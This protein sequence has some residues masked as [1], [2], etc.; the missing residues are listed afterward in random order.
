[1]I[2]IADNQSFHQLCEELDGQPFIT[3]DTEF[4]RERTYFPILALVQVSWRGQDPLLIDPLAVDDWAPF[5]RVL[6]N[7]EV[8]KVFHAG[9]QDV[10]IF[11]HQMK[12]LPQNLFDTQVAASM[13]GFGDQIGYG[14]LTAKLLGVQLAKGSSYTNW[15]Q[16]PLTKAQL[17]YAREDVAYLPDLYERLVAESELHGRLQ[18][19]QEE[20]N[21]QFHEAL[22]RPDPEEL[23]QKVKKGRNLRPR[24]LAVLR[25]LAKWRDESARRVNKPVRFL[26]PDEAMVE[27]SKIDRL[28]E[29]HLRARRNLQAG[30]ID[31]FGPVLIQLHSRARELPRDQWP[32]PRQERE[33]QPSEK[34]E[35]LAD[36]AWLL[37]KEIARSASIAP[38][39][40]VS[41]KN[42]AGFI[43]AY[44]RKKDLSRFSFYTGWRKEMVGEPLT[45]LIEGKL[46]V[47]VKRQKIIWE[48]APES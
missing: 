39:N 45:R 46:L 24:D 4:I 29:E 44:T 26:L 40:L 9:R 28:N 32:R 20:M 48:E 2:D 17:R 18:W 8:R 19:V 13:C 42:L 10:E 23:W 36:L 41:K 33:R 38:T 14:A 47:R 11:Y 27:L 25:A 37:V 31:R 43:E 35:A 16:R 7:A 3:L 21:G 6:K 12:A 22:F 30:F 1:M 15:L 5:H 34:S